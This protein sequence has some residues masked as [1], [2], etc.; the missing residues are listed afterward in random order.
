MRTNTYL[1]YSILC[2]RATSFKKNYSEGF[3]VLKY[4]W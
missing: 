2:S 1:I 3:S 4:I